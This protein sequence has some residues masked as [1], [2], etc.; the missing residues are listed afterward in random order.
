M[1]WSTHTPRST[2]WRAFPW[3]PRVGWAVSHQRD[4][5]DNFAS[6]SSVEPKSF[7][8]SA[9]M[10]TQLSSRVQLFVT[11]WTMIT[12]LL[13]PWIFQVRILERVAI[14]SSRDLSDPGIQPSSPTLAGRSFTSEPPG[15]PL[16]LPPDQIVYKSTKCSPKLPRCYSL[17]GSL[18]RVMADVD[19]PLPGSRALQREVSAANQEPFTGSL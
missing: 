16:F 13:C 9:C 1:C 4:E 5:Q 11:P 17:V 6:Y 2:Y 19:S 14:S 15:N 3:R 18:R 7:S 10:H 12:R 8:L